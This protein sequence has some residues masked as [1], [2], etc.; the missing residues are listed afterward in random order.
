MA[1]APDGSWL[2]S[3][4]RDGTVRT[5]DLPTEQERTTLIGHLGPVT[6]LAVAADDSWL[7]SGGESGIVRLW[8]VVTGHPW[9]ALTA[10]PDYFY[11]VEAVAAAPDASWLASG[12]DDGRYGSGM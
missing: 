11:R 1:V 7:V 4:G 12:G 10:D 5:W 8:D 9:G 6:S 3:G 2:A